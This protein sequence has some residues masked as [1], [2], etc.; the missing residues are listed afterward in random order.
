MIRLDT[1]QSLAKVKASSNGQSDT[2]VA[3]TGEEKDVREYLVLQ[4]RMLR[5]VEGKWVIWGTA[6]ETDV[7]DVLEGS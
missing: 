3:G 5:D 2:I 1:R 4:K 7:K 6:D